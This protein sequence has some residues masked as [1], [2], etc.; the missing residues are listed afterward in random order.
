MS[1]NKSLETVFDMLSAGQ[2]SWSINSI[3]NIG[4]GLP[5]MKSPWEIIRDTG[6]EPSVHMEPIFTGDIMVSRYAAYFMAKHI[7]NFWQDGCDTAI[8]RF[9]MA[10]MINPGAD[11]N[12]VMETY[13]AINRICETKQLNE[14]KKMFQDVVIK[15]LASNATER[16]DFWKQM[17][18]SFFKPK[19]QD[20]DYSFLNAHNDEISAYMDAEILREKRIAM[21][22]V[23]RD[24][25]SGRHPRPATKREIFALYNIAMDM[26]IAG[27][28]RGRKNLIAEKH[29]PRK[30]ILDEHYKVTSAKYANKERGFIKKFKERGI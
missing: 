14:T 15:E 29:V 21:D 25:N 16:S 18:H 7:N 30:Q 19:P 6:V 17:N 22:T 1:K 8:P 26:L 20:A 10:Y 4:A 9:E 23:W 3:I 28:D 5:P 11:F 12:K 24:I 2:E 13:R 27:A